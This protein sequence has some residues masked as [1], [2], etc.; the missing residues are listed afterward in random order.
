[1]LFSSLSEPLPETKGLMEGNA[2]KSCSH[3]KGMRQAD[4]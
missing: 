1:M 3:S 4:L 2:E